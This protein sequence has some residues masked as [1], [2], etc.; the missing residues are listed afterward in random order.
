VG[1]QLGVVAGVREPAIFDPAVYYGDRETDIAMTRLFG[2]FGPRFYAA[3]QSAWPLDQAA[4]TRPHALQPLPRAESL[5]PFR[6]RVRPAGARM[7]DQLLAESGHKKTGAGGEFLLR[8][9]VGR[10][11]L[12][13]SSLLPSI[14]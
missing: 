14:G 10:R 12:N 6:R 4:G 13:A 7:I 2:G 3:Y 9:P 11:G 8:C 5:Q 1:W